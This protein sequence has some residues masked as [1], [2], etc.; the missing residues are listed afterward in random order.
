M[1]DVLKI[2][3][4]LKSLQDKVTMDEVSMLKSAYEY[5]NNIHL[6]ETRLNKDPFIQHPLHVA[7]ILT[8]LN[9]DAITIC[10]ALL[11]EVMNSKDVTKEELCQKFGVEVANIVDSVSKLTN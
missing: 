9:V 7:Y 11:H 2:E 4:I 6:D 10:A 8:E 1:K 3:D 5:A